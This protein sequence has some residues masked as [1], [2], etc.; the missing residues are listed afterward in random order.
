MNYTHQEM[1]DL[2]ESNR[3]RLSAEQTRDVVLAENSNKNENPREVYK[4]KN[5]KKQKYVSRDQRE[6]QMSLTS[7]SLGRDLCSQEDLDS[8]IPPPARTTSRITGISIQQ[9]RVDKGL[10]LNV[11]IQT[12]QDAENGEYVELTA[13]LKRHNRFRELKKVYE[14]DC[15]EFQQLFLNTIKDLQELKPAEGKRFAMG[16]LHIRGARGQWFADMMAIAKLDDNSIAETVILN[17]NGEEFEIT[18]D[19]V[20]SPA[21]EKLYHRTGI[22]GNLKSQKPAPTLATAKRKT[23]NP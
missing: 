13:E 1:L 14:P 17:I 23:F 8:V 18:L 10:K 9:V 12:E 2:I 4:D 22:F 15:Y 16:R 21:Q 20:M 19:G 5:I 7:S 3:K 11:A 6:E